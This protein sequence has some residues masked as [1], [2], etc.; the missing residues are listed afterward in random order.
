[1]RLPFRRLVLGF[2]V[3]AL[4]LTAQIDRNSYREAYRAWREA[5]P[6]LEADA[7]SV[8]A[9]L[10]SRT[11]KDADLAASYYAAHADALRKLAADRTSDFEWLRDNALR[12][13]PDL[14][15][16]AD[17]IR[18]AT[19]EITALTAGA[20]T[21]SSDKDPAIQRLVQAFQREQ[22]ALE[23]L[24][25]SISERQDAENQAI[26]IVTAAE[27]SRATAASHLLSLSASLTQAAELM[28]HES[29]AWAA[30]YS[31]LATSA[32]EQKAAEKAA[33][34]KAAAEKAAA[35]APANPPPDKLDPAL[36]R[37]SITPLPLSRYVGSW[38]YQSGDMFHGPEPESVEVTVHEEN[39]H[40]KGTLS[41]RFKASDGTSA[42]KV[43]KI[44]FSGD[45]RNTR[46]QSF[47]L[48][49]A[50]GAMGKIELAPGGPL[51]VLEVIFEIEGPNGIPQAGVTLVK[52]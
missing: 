9:A 44:E 7:I 1:M 6:K 22:A 23:D 18:F 21:L 35:P 30:Y 43:V 45:F 48:Q 46:N 41:G 36:P 15:P 39:G 27:Q 24:K 42:E 4:C 5:D 31:K 51:N 50:D 33:A 13:L 10:S 19:N 25:T 11:S 16:V 34:D 26:K 3:G 12:T 49:T 52:Q 29:D 14:A 20:S 38:S 40:A 8:G 2:T 47:T 28:N 32:V 17:E 37:P